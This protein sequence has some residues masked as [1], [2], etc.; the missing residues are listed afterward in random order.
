MYQTIVSC[1]YNCRCIRLLCSVSTIVVVSDFCVVFLQLY[2]ICVGVGSCVVLVFVLV[3]HNIIFN[4]NFV[5]KSYCI[6]I[7]FVFVFV[8]YCICIKIAG[9]DEE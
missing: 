6:C 8:L 1:F 9:C 4:F 2:H 3:L 7:T 5:L